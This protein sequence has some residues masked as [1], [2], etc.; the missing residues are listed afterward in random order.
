VHPEGKVGMALSSS[1]VSRKFK[2]LLFRRIFGSE[3]DFWRFLKVEVLVLARPRLLL[4]LLLLLVVLLLLLLV[5]M[6]L[7]VRDL[8]ELSEEAEE[9][10]EDG[11]E[12]NL[13]FAQP[14]FITFVL[15][16][17]SPIFSR[18]LFAKHACVVSAL[19]VEEDVDVAD[20]S[21]IIH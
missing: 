13:L 8:F 9:E 20:I 1:S 21:K 19:L 16:S 10:E 14:E 4:L 3:I 2:F 12:E 6:V 11:H 15:V 5:V 17:C 18:F 7:L